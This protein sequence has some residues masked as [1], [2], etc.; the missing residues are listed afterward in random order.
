[1]E[2]EI[3]SALN[4]CIMALNFEKCSR[5]VAR[6]DRMGGLTNLAEHIRPRPQGSFEI[7]PPVPH[8]DPYSKKGQ[9]ERLNFL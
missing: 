7:L 3:A 4:H 2:V 6:I 5:S 9:K 1:M 8:K